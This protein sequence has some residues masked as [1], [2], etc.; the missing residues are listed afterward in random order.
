MAGHCLG[1]NDM[2]SAPH[3]HGGGEVGEWIGGGET[4]D[5]KNSNG[6]LHILAKDNNQRED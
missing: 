4:R 6:I 3:L 5:R 2:L 1:A